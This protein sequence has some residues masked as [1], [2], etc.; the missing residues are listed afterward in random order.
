MF[1]D[2][3]KLDVDFGDESINIELRRLVVERKKFVEGVALRLAR[4]IEGWG[5]E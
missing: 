2:W 4:T 5:A 1:R 3:I